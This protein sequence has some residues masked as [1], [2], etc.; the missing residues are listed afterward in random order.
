MEKITIKM[1]NPVDADK[2]LLTAVAALHS[3]TDKEIR[4]DYEPP[5][6]VEY[7][8]RWQNQSKFRAS[9]YWIAQN[10]ASEVVGCSTL[11]FKLVSENPTS[12]RIDVVVSKHWRRCSIGTALL[13]PLMQAA[14]IHGRNIFTATA[15]EGTSGSLFLDRFGGPRKAQK[16]ESHLRVTA[17]LRQKVLQILKVHH[18]LNQRYSIVWW[19]D[20]CPDYLLDSLAR[21]KMWMNAAPLGECRKE[22]WHISREWVQEE[23]TNRL[24][25]GISWWTIAAIEKISGRVVA[26]SDV[27]FS[28]YRN[29]MAMQEDTAVDCEHWRKGLASWLKA[30]LLMKLYAELNNIRLI[31]T[32]N[33]S[34]NRAILKINERL[35]FLPKYWLGKWELELDRVENMLGPRATMAEKNLLSRFQFIF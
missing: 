1:F 26:F 14:R 35:G 33:A 19:Q 23:E 13:I 6:I 8:S 24:G 25:G 21:A 9:L 10:S 29:S 15:K 34:D 2:E 5:P 12:A 4:P 17:E 30:S 32:R 31:V 7:I 16:I 3:A 18:T 11:R 28:K 20:K 22:T 27:H